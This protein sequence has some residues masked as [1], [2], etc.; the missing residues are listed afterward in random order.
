MYMYIYIY[1]YVYIHIYIYI[2]TNRGIYIFTCIYIYIHIYICMHVYVYI[3]TNTR[4]KACDPHVLQLQ[5]KWKAI[6]LHNQVIAML[7]RSR[8]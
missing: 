6:A 8:W 2:Y 1:T 7:A 4:Q 5:Q 3:H